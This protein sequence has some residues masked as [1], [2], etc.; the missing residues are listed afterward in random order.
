MVAAPLA[1]E[2]MKGLPKFH[3]HD[4]QLLLFLLPMP[5]LTTPGCKAKLETLVSLNLVA[6]FLVNN[7]L[8]NFD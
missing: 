8:A 1:G 6:S 4:I 2:I 3:A 5:V 7:T